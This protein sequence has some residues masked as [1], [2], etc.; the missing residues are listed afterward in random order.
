MAIA[1]KSALL[2]FLLVASYF[3]A[4]YTTAW[5]RLEQCRAMTAQEVVR[6]KVTGLDFDGAPVALTQNDV[7]ARVS[8]PFKVETQYMVPT[9]FHG[10]IYYQTYTTFPWTVRPGHPRVA[11]LL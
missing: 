4:G 10:S 9:G 6:T 2:L 3:A 7:S 5:A 1:K 11:H 8:G